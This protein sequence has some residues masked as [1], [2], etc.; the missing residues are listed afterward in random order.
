MP[1]GESKLLQHLK[2][3]VACSEKKTA[4]LAGGLEAM[5]ADVL[6]VNVISVR[7]IEDK[8]LLDR[9][10][11]SLPNYAWII[12]TSS[13]GVRFFMRRLKD[14][15]I[16][17]DARIMPKICAIGPATADEVR[18]WGHEVALIPQQYIGE[19]V[20]A[21]FE[22]Y[23]GR[24]RRLAGSRILLPRAKRARE[25]LPE[26]LAAAGA[27]V[28]VVPCYQTVRSEID[29]VT[30][31]ALRRDRYDLIVFTSSST[32]TNLVDILGLPEG[33]RILR[34]STVAVLGPITG[35]T[36]ESFGKLAEIVPKENTVPSLIE[37][38]CGYYARRQ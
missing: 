27:Q 37:A 38:I 36:V 30:K 16:K 13:Y 12:F 32:V 4:E 28:D 7:D 26:A 11:D 25:L 5:G 31:E 3:V 22:S 34:E 35:G 14:R 33:R 10:L 8:S 2:I 6:P 20:L 17:T 19:G 15:K 29:P 9:A 1:S 23:Y 21:A 18:Q 24:L